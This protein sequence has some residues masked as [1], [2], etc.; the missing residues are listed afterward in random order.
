MKD[1]KNI[2]GGALLAQALH[3][4][5]ISQVF[6]LSGG[7]CNPALEGLAERGIT[8]INCPHEQVAGHLADGVHAG[9]S[10]PCGVSGGAGGLCQRCAGD[11]GSLGR[12]YACHVHYRVQYPETS[13]QWRIQGD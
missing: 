10:I 12:A 1:T 13:G 8:I 11:D 4:K 9:H 2:R 7:F 5:G 6:T 3:E